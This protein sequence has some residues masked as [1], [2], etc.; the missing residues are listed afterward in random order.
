M[1]NLLF[2][3]TFE[4]SS[5]HGWQIQNDLKTVQGELKNAFLSVTN[6]DVVING[7]SRTDAG[8]H[9]K[10]Y[11]FNVKT[12]ATIPCDA[13]PVAL[14]T[15]L[16]PEIL[17]VSCEE[18]ALNFNAQ[19]DCVSKEYEYV[20]LNT[21]TLSPFMYKRACHY[22][23]RELDEKLLNGAAKFFLGEHDFSAFCASGAT[24]QSK[25]RT[26]Y[27]ASVK[28]EGDLVIFRVRGNGFLYNMVRIMAGTLLY[29]AEGKIKAEEIPDII[30]SGDRTKAGITAIPDGLYLNK[31]FYGSEMNEDK[32]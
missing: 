6:E 32:T 26:I 8:V 10:E 24:V 29:V 19:F 30:K 17:V 14:M 12:E 27:S 1:R 31:V 4:G 21:K 16:T 9:A 20:F 28:R 23:Y 5:F 2:K 11:Y 25:V 15:K 22:K 7:C 13:F 18:V 3:I